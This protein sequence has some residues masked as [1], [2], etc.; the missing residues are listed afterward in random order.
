MLSQ[1]RLQYE[2]AVANVDWL[3]AA[4]LKPS[5]ILLGIPAY[6]RKVGGLERHWWGQRGKGSRRREGRDE[7]TAR[8]QH[9]RGRTVPNEV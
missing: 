1:V 5:K 6:G 8:R 4:G 3:L 9:K 7:E 2:D